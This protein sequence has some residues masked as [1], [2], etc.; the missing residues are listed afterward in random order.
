MHAV[1]AVLIGGGSNYTTSIRR[2]AN[3]DGL[4]TIFGVIPLLDAGVEGI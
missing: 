2:S 4:A 3:N 1:F